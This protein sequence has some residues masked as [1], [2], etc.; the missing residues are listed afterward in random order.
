MMPLLLLRQGAALAGLHRPSD[1]LL[2]MA[3][4]AGPLLTGPGT[5]APVEVQ[6]GADHSWLFKCKSFRVQGQNAAAL[7]GHLAGHLRCCTTAC[8]IPCLFNTFQRASQGIK[9]LLEVQKAAVQLSLDMCWAGRMAKEQMKALWWLWG[10][11]ALQQTRSGHHPFLNDCRTEI[12]TC[13]TPSHLHMPEPSQL[14]VT[15]VPNLL[16]SDSTRHWSST[17]KPRVG[18]E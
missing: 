2:G 1:A 17:L 8:E 3:S 10:L 16:L 9:G 12:S 11:L 4:P 7:A 5:G 6:H 15:A 18:S 14:A 13:A